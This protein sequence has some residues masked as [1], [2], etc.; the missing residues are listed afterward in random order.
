MTGNWGLC[1]N[2]EKFKD[3]VCRKNEFGVKLGCLL[4]G[5]KVV[6]PLKLRQKVLSQLHNCHPGVSRMEALSRSFA[7]WP[8]IDRDIE[9]TVKNCRNCQMNKNNP[10]KAPIHPWEWP[11]KTWVRIH[12]NYAT[13]YHNKMFLIIVDSFSKWID[14][15]LSSSATSD[16]TIEKIRTVFV[17]FGLPEQIVTDNGSAFTSKEFETFLQ[18]NGIQQIRTAPYHAASNGQAERTD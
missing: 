13:P 3:F 4:W 7:W 11:N 5:S 10:I 16:E 2:S 18:R 1:E 6:I 12:L 9:N 14:V 8:N 15:I 17:N